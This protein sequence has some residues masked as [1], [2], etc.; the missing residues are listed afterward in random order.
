MFLLLVGQA[1]GKQVSHSEEKAE[2]WRRRRAPIPATTATLYMDPLTEH[3]GCGESWPTLQSIIVLME[4][5]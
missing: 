1:L 2:M 3:R 5:M 4:L